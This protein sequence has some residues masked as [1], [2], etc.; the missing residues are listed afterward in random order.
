MPLRLH[1]VLSELVLRGLD[2]TIL[3]RA[4]L[5]ALLL[6]RWVAELP[7]ALMPVLIPN[8]VPALMAELVPML[9]QL[10]MPELLPRA[11]RLQHLKA[12]ADQ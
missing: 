10:L 3:H 12:M 6:A 8:L 9:A 2:L 4:R 7:V 11:I 1:Q 5:V